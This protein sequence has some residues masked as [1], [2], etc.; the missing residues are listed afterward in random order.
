[1]SLHLDSLVGNTSLTLSESIAGEIYH[2]LLCVTLL[3]EE[4]WKPVPGIL[5]TLPHIPF[6]LRILLCILSAI[7]YFKF[8]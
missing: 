6:L 4:S 7:K 5:W 1:M 8:K 2:V 3:A